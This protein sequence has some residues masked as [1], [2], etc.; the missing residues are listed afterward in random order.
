MAIKSITFTTPKG[1]VNKSPRKV[2]KT[3]KDEAE[4]ISTG[5]N[6]T[7]VFDESPFA[8]SVFIIPSGGSVCSGPPKVNADLDK[9]Y[10]YT[11]FGPNGSTDPII[12]VTK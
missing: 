10:K 9:P 12:I 6:F 8:N 4:W 3:N 1:N 2:S 7:V 11:A 5:G